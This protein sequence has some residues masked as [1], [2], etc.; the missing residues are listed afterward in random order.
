MR[1]CASKERE[2]RSPKLEQSLTS[3]FQ[4]SPPYIYTEIPKYVISVSM[5]SF[6]SKHRVSA[7][8]PFLGHFQTEAHL[9]YRE[10]LIRN[11]ENPTTPKP[12]KP[13]P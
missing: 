3:K 13:N 7:N 4:V 10:F 5:L 6:V 12:L 9:D 8:R 1:R 2:E 11:Y